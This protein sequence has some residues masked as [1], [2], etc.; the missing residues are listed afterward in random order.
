M[1]FG[2]RFIMNKTPISRYPST[3]YRVSLKAVIENKHGELLCVK[4]QGSDW[5]LPGGGLDHGETIAEGFDRELREELEFDTSAAYSY[6]PLGHDIMFAPSK[7]TWQL[8][9]LFRVMFDS[10]P[11][12]SPGPDCSAVAFKHPELFK[13]SDWDMQ[14]IIYKWCA[15]KK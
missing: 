2:E 13:M 12:F 4:E 10:L 9:V 5:T 7:E 3:M 11:D 6:Q 14:Q 1:G 8:V 15:A